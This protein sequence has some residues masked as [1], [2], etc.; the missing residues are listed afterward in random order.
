MNCR[1]WRGSFIFGEP[2]LDQIEMKMRAGISQVRTP[3]SDGRIATGGESWGDGGRK[4]ESNP[5]GAAEQP[6]PV[7]KTGRPTGSDFLP[8]CRRKSRVT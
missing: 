8:C 6:E 7:L 3:G 2:I 1:A 5:P 4:R